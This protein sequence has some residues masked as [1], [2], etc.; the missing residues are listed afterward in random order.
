[1]FQV[2]ASFL[3]SGFLT[4][5]GIYFLPCDLWVKGYM[6]MGLVF[7]I[8]ST[9]SLAKT[10]RDNEESRKLVNR[11]VDAKTEKLLT[12]FEYKSEVKR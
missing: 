2:W 10:I 4:V 8:G 3:L 12:E 7:T 9:F 6:L 11:I 1:M 5:S